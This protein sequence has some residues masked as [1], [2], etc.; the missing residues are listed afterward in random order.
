MAMRSLELVQKVATFHSLSSRG[1][2]EIR[3]LL[4]FASTAPACVPTSCRSCPSWQQRLLLPLLLLLLND[5][6]SGRRLFRQWLECTGTCTPA[7]AVIVVA[8]V[9]VA[10]FRKLDEVVE[11]RI[12]VDVYEVQ[13][14]TCLQA[15]KAAHT[16]RCDARYESKSS[17]AF[18][19]LSRATHRLRLH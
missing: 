12:V 13:V 9:P 11:G 5:T 2:S 8:D 10:L 4:G 6:A 1:N 15:R 16:Q 19:S 3:K 7:I 14:E 17:E 18:A